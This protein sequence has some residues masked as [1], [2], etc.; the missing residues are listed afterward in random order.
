MRG[1]RRRPRKL[2]PAT[3]IR[4]SV[5]ACALSARTSSP[6]LSDARSWAPRRQAGGGL[7][8]R[9]AEVADGRDPPESG[10]GPVRP[11]GKRRR[12]LIRCLRHKPPPL[13]HRGPPEFACGSAGPPS[14][15]GGPISENGHQWLGAT[16]T[17]RYALPD[18]PRSGD[19]DTPGVSPCFRFLPYGVRR[20]ALAP[21]LKVERSTIRSSF[22]PVSESTAAAHLI[23]FESAQRKSENSKTI[24]PSPSAAATVDS[25]LRKPVARGSRPR[26]RPPPPAR[27]IA[28]AASGRMK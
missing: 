5:T 21:S 27:I 17:G 22:D 8:K 1:L 16:A 28:P 20:P 7:S 12:F 19:H 6:L 3:T 15:G 11:G 10:E 24:K 13:L 14:T 4:R 25:V 2:R 26:L 23:D 9:R 18:E